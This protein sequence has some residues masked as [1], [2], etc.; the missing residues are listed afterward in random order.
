MH[1]TEIKIFPLPFRFS[2]IK[3]E[4]RTYCKFCLIFLSHL[5]L[6]RWT[7]KIF[8]DLS[9]YL[10]VMWFVALKKIC[11]EI[12][13]EYFLDIELTYVEKKKLMI[14]F[15]VR[16]EEKLMWKDDK[17]IRWRYELENFFLDFKLIWILHFQMNLSVHNWHSPSFHEMISRRKQFA[18]RE[19]EA[20]L[21]VNL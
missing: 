3:H 10:P 6:L 14:E 18:I 11:S 17:T 21:N 7:W 8:N 15:E 4:I 19:W 16:T 1:S 13:F 5:A 20:C 2:S 12:N 9:P